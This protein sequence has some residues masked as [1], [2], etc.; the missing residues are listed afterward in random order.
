MESDLKNSKNPTNI[1]SRLTITI[2]CINMYQN[3][4]GGI[5]INNIYPMNF[6]TEY[7]SEFIFK[8]TLGQ[9][10]TRPPRQKTQTPI[11]PLSVC[12]N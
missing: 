5:A 10:L 3:A 9:T 6:K 8:T 12:I 4:K 2:H 11:T 1:S 7:L